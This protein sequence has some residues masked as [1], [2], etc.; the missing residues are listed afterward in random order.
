ME[1]LIDTEM[2]KKEISLPEKLGFTLHT[3]S[4]NFIDKFLNGFGMCK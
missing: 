3:L 1:W 2:S 4:S